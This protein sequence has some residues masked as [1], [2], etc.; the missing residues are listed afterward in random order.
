MLRTMVP[1]SSIDASPIGPSSVIGA[2]FAVTVVV[3]VVVAGVAVA[4]AVAVAVVVV[5]VVFAVQ[6]AIANRK[7]APTPTA[8]AFDFMCCL[9]RRGWSPTRNRQRHRAQR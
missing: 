8:A 3:V 9:I 5:V 4:V 6:V 1:S 7:H 2:T